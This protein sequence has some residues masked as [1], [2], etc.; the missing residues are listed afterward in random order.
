LIV[1]Q[2]SRRSN[3]VDDAGRVIAADAFNPALSPDGRTLAFLRDENGT[4]TLWMKNLNSGAE[5]RVPFSMASNVLDLG[6]TPEGRLIISAIAAGSPEIFAY[7][8]DR[9]WQPVTTGASR[10]P[11]VS[12]DGRWLAFSRSNG[13]NWNLWLKNLSTGEERPLFPADCNQITPAWERDSST[14]VYASDCG[15]GLFLTALVSR[16]VVP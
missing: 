7:K 8:E 16:R 3:L 15:R 10:F 5:S 13:V 12:P 14:L 4:A 9:G 1:E 2:D 11:A 6:F